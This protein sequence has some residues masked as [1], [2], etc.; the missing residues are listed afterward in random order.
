MASNGTVRETD[1]T[2]K[3]TDTLD[4]AARAARRR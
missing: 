3:A 2:G 1:G 4:G